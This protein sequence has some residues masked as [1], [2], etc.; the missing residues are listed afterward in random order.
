MMNYAKGGDVGEIVDTIGQLSQI[1]GGIEMLMTEAAGQAEPDGRKALRLFNAGGGVEYEEGG[2][3][4]AVDQVRGG[5]RGDDE[6]L[7]H[8]SPEEYEAIVSMW[9][10]PDINPQTG[11]PEYGF[12]SKLWKKV[13]KTVKKI[14]KSPIFQF[15]APLALNAFVPGLGA[16]IGS[17][18]GLA[19][20]M[21]SHVGNSIIRGGIGAAGGGKEGALSGVVNALTMGG[22]GGDI[23]GKLGLSGTMGDIAGNALIGGVGGEIG[24]GGFAQG[25]LGNAMNAL[26]QKPLEEGTEN[27]LGTI[28]NPGGEFPEGSMSPVGGTDVFG[29]PI[30]PML[31]QTTIG[32]ATIGDP[33]GGGGGNFLQRGWDWVKDNPLLAGAGAVGLYGMMGQGSGDISEGAQPLPPQFT[34]SLPMNYDFSRTQQPMDPNAYY[35]Y[36]QVGAQQPG[37]HTFFQP[38]QIGGQGTPDTPG[39]PGQPSDIPF[40]AGGRSIE[41]IMEQLRTGLGATGFEEGGYVGYA[42]GGM[43]G[44]ARG[45]GSGRDDT[46]EALLSDGEFVM[47]AETVSMLGDGSNDEG[48]RRLEELRQNLRK[49][50]GK[51][52]SR[53]KIS[54]K[55]KHPGAYMKFKE[56]GSVRRPPTKSKRL[57]RAM[58]K[59][60]RRMQ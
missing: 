56:G 42:N 27:L 51:G 30:D 7:L 52:L 41:D 16:A 45:A 26:V 47:D 49:H 55:A 37:E 43:P 33:G 54:S 24:G 44:Y 38:N 40:P 18:L 9:G 13:K 50:K 14:V 25:A 57:V 2:L 36:G 59:E 21:A 29:N 4:E 35:T 6:V 39:T 23:A 5:G 1:P 53:G 31:P 10:E 8:V 22:A 17:K 32:G 58:R 11:L 19:G 60:A 20:K 15:V 46:I 3:A 28:F 12:L 48:A 34:E